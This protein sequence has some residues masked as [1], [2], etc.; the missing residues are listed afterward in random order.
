MLTPTLTRLNELMT[1]QVSPVV[2]SWSK[3]AVELRPV[4]TAEELAALH[5][6][7]VLR[8]RS[9]ATRHRPGCAFVAPYPSAQDYS[10][11]EILAIPFCNDAALFSVGFLQSDRTRMVVRI[12]EHGVVKCSEG[13]QAA[14]SLSA[15]AELLF[16]MALR[17]RYREKIWV[18]TTT[19][20][21]DGSQS[22]FMDESEV[23]QELGLRKQLPDIHQLVR[24][25][26]TV[27]DRWYQ[28]Y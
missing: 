8:F 11:N 24:H 16:G 22:Y 3:E 9:M 4:Y 19:G 14:H 2:S 7:L 10:P 20:R 13:D 12:G 25:T 6:H 15:T 17:G 27:Q 1:T 5:S 21:F 23:W 26:L 28:P 18:D